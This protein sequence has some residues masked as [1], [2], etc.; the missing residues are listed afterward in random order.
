MEKIKKWILSYNSIFLVFTILTIAISFQRFLPAHT[1]NGKFCYYNN[2][3]LFKYSVIHLLEFK[4]MYIPY[5]NEGAWDLYKYSPTFAVFM[6]PYAFLPDLPGL[7]CWNLTNVLLV[8]WAIRTL[9]TFRDSSKQLLL[10]F[11]L[12]ELMLSTQSSQSNALMVALYLLTFTAFENRKIATAVILIGLATCIKPYGIVIGVLFL[13]YPNKL[14]FVIYSCII[15]VLFVSLPLLITSLSNLQN[16][17]ISWFAMLSGDYTNSTGISVMA[18][19]NDFS[20]VAVNKMTVIILGTLLTVST[21]L[22]HKSYHN[23][24][25]RI[26]ILSLFLIWVVI[27]NHKSESPTFIIPVVGVGLWFFSRPQNQWNLILLIIVLILTQLSASDLFPAY[28]R[29]ELF[30]KIHIKV[31]PCF[32]VWI[33]ILIRIYWDSLIRKPEKVS[34]II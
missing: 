25:Y 23:Y 2:F 18:L 8:F 28:V 6:L 30:A 33:V 16:Q 15:G 1:F 14:R 27:F 3:I 24:S 17:Y 7:I 5:E 29:K 20:G 12:P 13:F 32:I 10:W 22:F 21:L 31:I 34:R 4:D 19:I 26:L 9:P 11:I